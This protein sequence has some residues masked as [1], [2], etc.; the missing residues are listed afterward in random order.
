MKNIKILFCT[1]LTLLL[2]LGFTSDV[3]AAEYCCKDGSIISGIGARKNGQEAEKQDKEC[4][5]SKGTWKS[6][7]ECTGIKPLCEDE[8]IVNALSLGKNVYNMVRWLTPAIL[9]IMGSVDFMRAAIAGKAEDME[10]HRKRFFN[11]IELAVLVFLIISIFEWVTAILAGNGTDN[12]NSWV[13]CWAS[14]MILK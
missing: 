8:E 2:F 12:A 7:F 5:N 14:L 9:I 10:K 6:E 1:L 11:R 4:G 13:D 3:R